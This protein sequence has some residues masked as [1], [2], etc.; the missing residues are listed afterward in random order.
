MY[1]FLSIIFL[2]QSFALETTIQKTCR[3]FAVDEL[4]NVYFIQNNSI[5]KQNAQGT[6]TFRTSELN[7]GT[8]EN[9]DITNPLKPFIYYKGINKIVVLDN[10]LSH[11]GDAVDLFA[12]EYDQVELVAG[13]RGDAYWMWDTRNSELIRVDRNFKKLSSSGNLSVL[14]SKELHPS[15]ILER[16]NSLYLRDTLNGVFVF[17]IYANYKTVLPIKSQNDIQV[18]NNT[19]IYH[20]DKQIFFLK[21]DWISEETL[22]LPVVCNKR[23]QFF[24]QKL[25]IQTDDSIQLWKKTETTRN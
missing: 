3:D 13:S 22:D 12:Y 24:N 11:Q 18:V 7:Y 4:G 25:Y 9:L 1:T 16:G 23:I 19:L 2:I 21:D 14:L 10:T 8:I 6:N 20:S 5:E 15:Q 17:D